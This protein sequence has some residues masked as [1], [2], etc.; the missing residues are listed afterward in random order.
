MT[1]ADHERYHKHGPS[2]DPYD[3]ERAEMR[4]WA[5]R[6]ATWT[7]DTCPD[8]AHEPDPDGTA[9]VRC[10][11]IAEPVGPAEIAEHLTAGYAE[12]IEAIRD[13]A[14]LARSGGRA[15]LRYYSVTTR[16]YRPWTIALRPSDDQAIADERDAEYHR[17]VRADR[18]ASHDLVRPHWPIMRA[19]AEAGY[20]D[21]VGRYWRAPAAELAET[22]N[23]VD[24]LE[25]LRLAGRLDQLDITR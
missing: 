22:V 1:R 6:A 17:I 14:Q 25:R 20:V 7:P 3:V 15:I 4:A 16:P 19:A 10:G 23:L 8:D 24:G 18:D 9:C 2:S 13:R 5:R 21:S 11:I 12:H